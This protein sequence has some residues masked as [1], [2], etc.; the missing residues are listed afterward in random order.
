MI[1]PDANL[2]LYAYDE[3]SPFHEPARKWWDD[4]LSGTDAVGLAHPTVFAFLRI[5]TNPRAYANP[6]PLDEA[7]GHIERWLAR[8]VVQILH[9]PPD[10]TAQVIAL[11]K[12]AG[13]AAG[14]LV[15]DAQIAALA[16]HYKATVNTADR[17]FLRFKL[18][19]CVFP[20]DD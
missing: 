10:H 6:M 13:G 15:T 14:N 11:L 17:D 1:V 18:V 7:S 2:L 20:L 9:P 4:C 5:A 12:A 8:R 16:V 3:S 19:R